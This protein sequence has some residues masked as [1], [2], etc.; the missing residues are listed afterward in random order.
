VLDLLVLLGRPPPRW[1]TATWIAEDLTAAYPYRSEGSHPA[2][3]LATYADR[4]T[5]APPGLA[6]GASW[7]DLDRL[8]RLVGRTVP[9]HRRAL[10]PVDPR[11]LLRR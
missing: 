3:R 8:R 7:A 10:W 9:W 5:F 4:A 1:R 2:L 11:P 6:V